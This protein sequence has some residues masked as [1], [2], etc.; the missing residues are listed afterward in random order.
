M[1]RPRGR[2]QFTR[3]GSAGRT[4]WDQS[5]LTVAM[6]AGAAQAVV[7]LSSLSISNLTSP[8]GTILRL[9]G[10]LLFKSQDTPTQV[11][12]AAGISVVTIDAFTAGATPDPLGD[13]GQDWYW[14]RG[15][16]LDLPASPA[17][18]GPL[19][20]WDVDLRTS[21]RLREGFRLALVID[22]NASTIAIDVSVAFRGLWKMP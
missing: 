6:V 2:R 10:G 18:L 14:W 20:S 15:A 12:I 8:T 1:P 16:T 13:P 22:K 4:S 11:A 5:L 7:D 21:R 3:R 17:A 9:I 19:P